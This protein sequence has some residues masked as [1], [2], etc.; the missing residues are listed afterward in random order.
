MS[1]FILKNVVLKGLVSTA[2]LGTGYYLYRRARSDKDRKRMVGMTA[3]MLVG[4]K[5]G[6]VAGGILAGPAGA[7]AGMTVGCLSGCM[8]GGSV[9]EKNSD[10]CCDEATP[11]PALK[12]AS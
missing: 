10:G 7:M 3:G 11:E 12:K 9:V 1:S 6:A 4:H 8:V 2:A 5:L